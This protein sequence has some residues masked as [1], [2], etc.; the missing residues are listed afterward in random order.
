MRVQAWHVLE[1]H[2]CSLSGGRKKLN[3]KPMAHFIFKDNVIL[4]IIVHFEHPKSF[5]YT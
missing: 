3:R 2:V 4:H 5:F 1:V